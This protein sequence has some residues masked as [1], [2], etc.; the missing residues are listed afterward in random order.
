[1]PSEQPLQGHTDVDAASSD[2]GGDRPIRG[3]RNG[4]THRSVSLQGTRERENK[5]GGLPGCSQSVAEAERRARGRRQGQQRFPGGQTHEAHAR[6]A[7]VADAAPQQPVPPQHRLHDTGCLGRGRKAEPHSAT[8]AR[9]GQRV[10]GARILHRCH[11]DTASRARRQLERH[12]RAR[13][14]QSRWTAAQYCTAECARTL[15]DTW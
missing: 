1:M 7:R 2:I 10:E 3:R 13:W 12:C 14:H 5:G 11:E 6:T 15:D 8:K 4:S 9:V